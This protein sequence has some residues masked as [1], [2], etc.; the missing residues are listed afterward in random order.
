MAGSPAGSRAVGETPTVRVRVL[1]GFS[2]D[3]VPER[4]LGSR[5]ARTLLKALA[6]GRGSP[7]AVDRLVDIVWGDNPPARPVDQVGV[8]VSRLR[9]VLGADRV[10]RSDAGY[11]LHAEWLDID[12]LGARVREAA[13]AL[14]ADRVAAARAAADA[15]MALA[16]GPVLPEEDGDWVDIERAAAE[17]LASA[18]R[19][20]AGEAA[21]RAGDH[22]AAVAA[23]EDVLARDPYDEAALRVLMRA[24]VAGGRPA[25]ALAAYVRVRERL[26]EDLGVSPTAETEALHDAI[27]MGD[28]GA[29]SPTTT[30]TPSTPSLPGRDAEVAALD[31]ALDR[32]ATRRSPVVVVVTGDAGMGKT[33]LVDHWSARLDARALVLAGR[34]DPLGRDLPLQ[35]IADAVAAHLN[36]RPQGERM[37]ALEG[38]A[39]VLGPLLGIGPGLEGTDSGA[40][41]V[42][43][44]DIGRIRLFA[45]LSD[46]VSRLAEDR[47]PVLVV[48]D[49]HFAGDS[50]QAWL[51][52]A[53]RRMGRLLL[54][55]TTRP[56][57]AD[58]PIGAVS[59]DL[60]PL[61]AAATAAVVGDDHAAELHARTG[62]VPLLLAALA[63]T[64][65]RLPRTLEDAVGHR[66]ESIGEAAATVRSAA[67]LGTDI[68][69]DLL[70]DVLHV[71]AVE[72]LKHLEAAVA[73]GL[74]VERGAGFAFRHELEREVLDAAAG[75]ARKSLLHRQAGR[76]L[77]DR[78]GRDPLVV[79]VH[80]RLGGDVDLAVRSYTRAAE[81]ALSRY[82]T[83]AAEA[84]V[85]AALALEESA[86]PLAMR[87]RLRMAMSRFDDAADDAQRALVRGGGAATLE[88]AGWVAYY[89]RRYDEALAF[90]DAAV[91][92]AVDPAVRVSSLALAGRVR[93][94]GGALVDA[95]AGLEQAAA[96]EAPP[97]VRA[98]AAIWLAQARVHQGRPVEALA[99]LDRALVDPDRLGHPFAPLHGRFTRALAL[100]QLGRVDEALRACDE[101]D[102]LVVRSGEPGDRMIG[103]AA[104]TRAWI[105]RWTGRAAEADERN[106]V[107]VAAHDPLGSLGE[108]HYA[109]LLDLADGRLLA[110]DDGG[111]ADLLDRM[112]DIETWD[113]TMSWHQR[114]RWKLIR[115]R[116]AIR[117]NDTGTA[118]S[119]SA[120]VAGD[121]ARRGARRYELLALATG[122]LAGDAIAS[123][124]AA[125]NQVVSGLR[126]CAALDGRHLVDALTRLPGP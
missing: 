55:V 119:L 12:E 18:A 29:T 65:D 50:T 23:A 24:H 57:H 100:G 56:S 83:A 110:D 114:H 32:A 70:A 63:T 124:P 49:L 115:A 41:V 67:V 71:P 102:A 59:I 2:V 36:G 108:A 73:A 19:R 7:V 53:V 91:Q 101:L 97:E 43:D 74:L 103:P 40:T 35:P 38:N 118:A 27:V 99:L 109:G 84:H 16:R 96:S 22:V 46:L 116:L 21:W 39:D 77:A 5:K 89:R 48:D 31:A 17:A 60:G 8:L 90:A 45:A 66:V 14:A 72:L 58:W 107:A 9:G 61:D 104:N 85:Q 120:D 3:D 37:A 93:H 122:A 76:A 106:L 113:G 105:L 94:A 121:A 64:G 30:P 87:A 10:V 81:V 126:A 52:F 54:V 80:A 51:R 44:P 20:I 112:A 6:L 125:L 25:S 34:C 98:L 123:D 26:V 33:R 42:S 86:S 111:A 15:A 62:G 82:D 1:G 47:V 4:D 68:D 13:D 78:G 11:S 117:D 75:A 95:A 28:A 92:R 69:L 79:A 88:V